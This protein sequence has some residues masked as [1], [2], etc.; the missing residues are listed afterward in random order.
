[1]LLLNK[2]VEVIVPTQDNNGKAIEST[3]IQKAIEQITNLAGGYSATEVTGA[4]YSTEEQRLM[5]DNN[6]NYEWYH[7]SKHHQEIAEHLDAII[8][9]LCSEYG[10]EA[11]SVKI[12]GT[13]LIIFKDDDRTEVKN[14]MIKRLA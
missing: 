2:T 8:L 5:I 3:I 6:I 12:D 9:E 11:V 10:Q 1:M 14:E 13:L 7:D 4:W